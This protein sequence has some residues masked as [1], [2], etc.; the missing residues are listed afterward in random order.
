MDV[1]PETPQKQQRKNKRGTQKSKLESP[2]HK[3]P[4]RRQRHTRLNINHHKTQPDESD[5]SS[6]ESNVD[7]DDDDDDEEEPFKIQKILASRTEPRSKWLEIGKKMNS[8]EIDNGSRWVQEPLQDDDDHNFQERF[9]VK[10]N[11]HSYL[12]VSWETEAD[13][14][15]QVEGAK[16]YLNT[17]F[18]KSHHG[19]LFDSDERCDGDYFDPA[20][21]QIDRILDVEF[22]ESCPVKSVKDENNITNEELGITLDKS[23]PDYENGW[24]REFWSNGEAVR[25]QKLHGNSSGILF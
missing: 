13:L 23:S 12:H 5:E 10:W 9:L 11:D 4:A 1:D 2:T 25:I 24:G 22:P 20:W 8:N 3:S 14:L 15:D 17:F 18:R 16:S 19:I 7:D 6:V 21:T